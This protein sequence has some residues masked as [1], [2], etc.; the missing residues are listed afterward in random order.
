MG[1]AINDTIPYKATASCSDPLYAGPY[2]YVWTFSDGDTAT[3]QYVTHV[4]TGLWGSVSA[5][6]VCTNAGTNDRTA[7]TTH[8]DTIDLPTVTVSLVSPASGLF[9]AKNDV[10][11]YVS[12]GVS[13]YSGSELEYVWKFDN[14]DTSGNETTTHQWTTTGEHT[15]SVTVTDTVT[16]VSSDPTS[17]NTVTVFEV[18]WNERGSAAPDY[19]K[20]AICCT[21]SDGKIMMAGGVNG[22]LVV[23]TH[24]YAFDG[25]NWTTLGSLKRARSSYN[26]NFRLLGVTLSNGD[27]IVGGG[28]TSGTTPLFEK[29]SPADDTWSYI[30][31]SLTGFR[32]VTSPGLLPDDKVLLFG[33]FDGDW[34]F[35][36]L[37][38]DPIGGGG[39]I[40]GRYNS[41]DGG[42]TST[43]AMTIAQFSN[44]RVGILFPIDRVM[45]ICYGHNHFTKISYNESTINTSAWMIECNG[46]VYIFASSGSTN[47]KRASMA[48][49][50]PALASQSLTWETL[51]VA[52]YP[53]TTQWGYIYKNR[54]IVVSASTTYKTSMVFDTHTLTWIAN[55]P[56][57]TIS[58]DT[59]SACY[60]GTE[61]CAG[62]INDRLVCNVIKTDTPFTSAPGILILPL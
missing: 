40:S 59:G 58:G 11:T 20:S 38:I 17:T 2:T 56:M 24:C 51:P 37:I 9:Y 5:T 6:V 3:G 48:T 21:M 35:T 39:A 41:S 18:G 30:E 62:V 1:Y 7:T 32:Q 25:V 26:N 47:C 13:S 10:V 4:Y 49:I 50:D 28:C 52:P 14:V 55:Y 29:Y 16:E 22:S 42:P 15:A 8:T 19:L 60:Q 31:P 12:D 34:I 27:I 54:Y 44:N 57:Y 46:Y 36:Y 61:V 23:Q 43:G 33:G 53:L 45:C